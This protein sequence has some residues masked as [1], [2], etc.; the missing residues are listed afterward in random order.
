MPPRP[1]K[2]RRT[3]KDASKST[4]L[5]VN[6]GERSGIEEEDLRWALREGAVLPEEAIHDVRVLHR[7]S[8]VEVDPDKAEQSGRVS[9]RNEAQGKRDPVGDRQVVA[10]VGGPGANAA[11]VLQF[12]ED[13]ASVRRLSLGRGGSGGSLLR[14]QLNEL[15][16]AGCVCGVGCPPTLSRGADGHRRQSP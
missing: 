8:F 9:R 3:A 2:L 10:R 1:P 16:A 6:R 14:E 7:F 5:F 4:K 11:S 12:G 15:G 13:H